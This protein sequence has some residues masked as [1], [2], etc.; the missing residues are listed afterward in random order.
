MHGVRQER[1]GKKNH[2]R[3]HEQAKQD[4][5]AKLKGREGYRHHNGPKKNRHDGGGHDG[6]R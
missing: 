4:E 3:N 1:I 5:T 6:E 2:C